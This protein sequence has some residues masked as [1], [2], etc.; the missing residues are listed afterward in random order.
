MFSAAKMFNASKPY[1]FTIYGDSFAISTI[2]SSSYT[3]NWGDG[4]TENKTG[5]STHNY[6][7]TGTYT[8]A[9]YGGLKSISLDL[10]P[11]NKVQSLLQWGDI[12]WTSLSNILR[13]TVNLVD[14]TSDIPNLTNVTLLN[15]SFSQSNYTGNNIAKW[16][17]KNITNM[18]FCFAANYVFNQPIGSWDVAN[19]TTMGNM[20]YNASS[21]NQDLSNWNVNKVSIMDRMFENATSFN[22]DLSVW[23]LR[24]SG[25][26]MVSMLD[27]CGMNTEN[28]SR[29]L[30]GWANRVYANG[31]PNS[32]TLGASGRT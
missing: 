29:T 18:G 8:I 23:P 17:T 4:T 19:V 26:Q 12:N 32:T 11:G 15:L 2:A 27:N 1:M 16:N 22:Q 25:V 24:T 14:L 3:I 28:Y 6:V 30:I 10:D 13:G 7:S 31:G 21:F 9:I 20:F 5:T